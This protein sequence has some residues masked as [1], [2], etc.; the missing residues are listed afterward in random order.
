MLRTAT[1]PKWLG[2]LVVAI[3]CAALAVFLGRWQWASAHDRAREE[4]VREVQDRPVEPITAAIQPLESFPDDGSGQ[5]VRA[6][7][8]YS[9]DDGF[10]VVDRLL[11]GRHGGWAVERFVVAE[12]GANLAVVRGWLPEGE[13]PPAPPPGEL[14]IVASLAPGEAPDTRSDLPDGQAGTID[15]GRLVNA[16]P[17]EIYNGFGFA[18]EEDASGTTVAA[19]PLERVPPPLPDTS[20][21]WRNASY[22]A[23]WYVVAAFVLWMWWRMMRQESRGSRSPDEPG[24]LD[25]PSTPD[26]PADPPSPDPADPDRGE[27]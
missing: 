1:R 17:G 12:T 7:G 11:D 22:A 13:E 3:A 8:K 23:Q 5:R 2:L 24:V 27:T 16:W 10:V 9:V 14:E 18:V 26:A 19:G 6:T 15:V 21:D 25:E 20:L 4:A